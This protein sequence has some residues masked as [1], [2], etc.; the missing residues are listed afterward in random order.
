MPTGRS[1]SSGATRTC[2]RS[3]AGR[4]GFSRRSELSHARSD[5]RQG[6]RAEPVRQRLPRAAAE[7]AALQHEP[8]RQPCVHCLRHLP[9]LGQHHRIL[10]V[11]R[12]E[13]RR[14]GRQGARQVGAARRARTSAIRWMSPSACARARCRSPAPRTAPAGTT[15][16]GR[17][18]ASPPG[19]ARSGSTAMP[20]VTGRMPTRC[21]SAPT[22]TRR[23]S[24]IPAPAM[25][26][27]RRCSSARARR[28]RISSSR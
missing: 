6:R 9:R 26:P 24:V 16:S 5:R 25:S 13:R 2:S 12:I 22:R 23:C 7:F 27:A 20:G 18:A 14:Q 28:C 11:F 10:G 21:F 15:G 19:S 3:P 4:C 8:V 1:A 17:M